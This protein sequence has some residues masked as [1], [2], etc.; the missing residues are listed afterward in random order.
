[1]QTGAK[2]QTPRRRS[3]VEKKL[4]ELGANLAERDGWWQPTHFKS[5]ESEVEA[6]RQGV[7]LADR[8]PVTK[9]DLRAKDL[10]AVWGK[11][12]SGA[13]P[14][15]SNRI[16]RAEVAGHPVLA[17]R[18]NPERVLLHARPG[19]GKAL[20]GA[21][22]EAA[23]GLSVGVTDVTS[24]FS[25]FELA[26][27]SSA[28]ILRKLGPVA[29]PRDDFAIVQARYVGV[30]VITFRVDGGGGDRQNSLRLY[31]LHVPRDLGFYFWS[32]LEDAGHEFGLTPYGTEARALLCPNAFPA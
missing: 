2:S 20:E 28:L 5:P 23:S 26:G 24:G 17:A 12:A 30:Q 8:S 11:V 19:V 18:L 3:A 27:P 9:L 10:P 13:A 21:I 16:S 14:P 25:V 6:V 15:E 7:G 22:K 1:M 31:Q 32:V 4:L 29:P